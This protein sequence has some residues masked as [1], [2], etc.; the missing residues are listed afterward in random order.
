MLTL[1]G[2]TLRLGGHLILDRA[3][4]ALLAKSRV[5]LVGRNG[6]GKS[7]LLKLIAASMKPT[8]DRLTPHRARGS[9]KGRPSKPCLLRRASDGACSRRSSM[10]PNRT[11]SAKSTRRA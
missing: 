5:G 6:A 9:V 10:Q 3:S 11:A 4:A 7:S 1:D 2:I 8:T